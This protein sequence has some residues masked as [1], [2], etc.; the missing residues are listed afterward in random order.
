MRR[1]SFWACTLALALTL[2]AGC[3]IIQR[4]SWQK[5][6]GKGAYIPAAICTL[7]GAGVGTYIQDQR[8]GSSCA[9]IDGV[10]QCVE[11]DPEYWKGA[12]IGAAAG[13][14]L[15]GI[16]GHVF[17][18]PEP[19][20]ATPPPPPPPPA[21]EP[22]VQPPVTKRRIVLRGITFDFNKAEI[23]D[24]S[25][26]V[27]DEAVSSLRENPGVS[28]EVAGYTDSVGG[29]EYNQALSIRRAE[30]VYRYLVNRGIAP[31]RMKVVGYGETR[32]VADNSTE[33]GRAQNRRVE[34]QVQQ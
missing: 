29:E 25:R 18:D 30:A 7:V 15:C 31:E 11:D 19:Q 17:L 33:A 16:A 9:E 34:L 26:P 14:L 3:A 24:E 13:A 20:P 6:L 5:P 2:Q 8:P 10:R 23:R 4:P 32:P 22:P 12:I 21:V 28:L 27:L 1:Q